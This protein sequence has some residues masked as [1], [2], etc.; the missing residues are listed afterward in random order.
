LIVLAIIDRAV[1]DD[2][3]EDCW[4]GR[5]DIKVF[6]I[7]LSVFVISVGEGGTSSNCSKILRYDEEPRDVGDVLNRLTGCSDR[8]LRSD[9]EGTRRDIC[10]V[11]IEHKEE[12]TI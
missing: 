6:G 11:D 2:V 4:D 12:E 10:L 1:D 5:F 9:T 7:I 8:I 3:D